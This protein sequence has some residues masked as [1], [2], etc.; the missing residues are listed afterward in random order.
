[1]WTAKDTSGNTANAT[2][3]VN[4]VDTTAPKLTPPA[5]VTF[6]AT[7]LDN[8]TVPLGNATA[9]D[10]EPV[11]ITNNASKTFP[12]GK[13]TIV[14][15]AKDTSG[16]TANATQTV[17]V[18]DTTAPKL[19][20]P[21]NVT[22]EATS[23]DNNTVPLGTPTVTDIEQVTVTNDAPKVF[24]VGMTTV[25]WTAK[26]TSGNTANAT[27]TVLV[28]DTTAPK[29]TPPANVTFEA[30]SVTSNTVP[31]GNATATD[32]EPVTIT[33]NASKTFPLGKTTIV[34]TAKD[35]AGNISNVTQT[36][37]VVDTTA[38]KLTPPANVTFEAVS[39]TS[40][41]VPL[42][43]AT[44]TDIEPVTITNNAPSVFQ[45]GKTTVLWTAKDTSGNTAN[46]TQTV[47]VVDTTAPKLTPPAN[48]TFE[49]TSLDNNTVPLGN[50]TATDI[51]P[52]TITN[53]ASKTF[54]LGKTTIVWTAKDAAGNISNVTQTVNVVDT[55]APKIIPPHTVI[56]NATSPTSNQVSIGNATA[57]DN[58]KV[59][60]ITNDAPAVFPFG[61]TTVTWTAKDVAGNTATSTQLVEVVDHSP[62]QLTIP[63][64]IVINATSFVTPVSTGQS[65]ATGIID[66]S[67]KITN[68]STGLFHI[69]KTIVQWT[70][71]DKF[72]NTKSLDQTINVLACGKPESLYNVIT[73][74][75]NSDTLTGS[76]VS[77]LILGLDGNDT[78]HAGPAGDC[79]IAGNGDN[80]IFGGSGNDMIIAGNG[81]NII[82]GSTGNELIYV[83]TGSNIIQGGT[84]HN[85]CYLG[86]PSADTVVNCQAQKQ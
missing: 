22:F 78:I 51:E 69:G 50:A 70:A 59:V 52:V 4:V 56:V 75:N 74:T 82:K 54:P 39:V 46:A 61:N 35:A 84:G 48:V 60:S 85:T 23:L 47:N 71:V 64:D 25:I 20:P 62:P 45:L 55:T 31:L 72:G 76:P 13:T 44:A 24:P 8:N 17:L 26:D 80:I 10:I 33:N 81:N 38:P 27:Q 68:N 11:T 3:T 19:T 5:N 18:H 40:N 53:N 36:V 14:W 86:N 73:G 49:A 28:H 83:G 7:S 67:P 57:T 65:T 41:T 37:N 9:T 29:L 66:T 32:I 77:N 58:T 12:L 2:Q 42:G 43:N 63:S 21:A 79:I 16:N 30:V 34:W 6:E 1:M 15:T